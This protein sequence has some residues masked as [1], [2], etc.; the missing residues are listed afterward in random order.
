MEKVTGIGGF[1]FRSQSPKELNDWYHRNL[2]IELV[3]T[4]Y[5]VQPWM[6]EAGP[7]VFTAYDEKNGYLFR[8]GGTWILNFRVS[9]LDKMVAQLQAAGIEVEVD[10]N[11]YPNGRFAMLHDPDG[12]PIQLWEMG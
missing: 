5:D 1:F 11:T 7:T 6:Q 9:S 4:S 3:P 10:P 12:N 8:Y 2:G